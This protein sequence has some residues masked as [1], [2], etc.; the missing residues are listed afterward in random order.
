LLYCTVSVNVSVAVVSPVQIAETVSVE[1]TGLV[2]PPPPP[3][4][5]PLPHPFAAV[6]SP[7][8]ATI[9]AIVIHRL[10]R[11]PIGN[12]SSPAAS[13]TKARPILPRTPAAWLL[14]CTVTVTGVALVAAV[15]VN[16]EGTV[17]VSPDGSPVQE[18][19]TVP[20]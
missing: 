17:H 11:Q 10:R 19:V 5:L 9:S 14:V 18:K 15:M 3:P 13:A 7:T 12:S 16:G 20:E 8:D 4:L 1:V 2:F 6:S